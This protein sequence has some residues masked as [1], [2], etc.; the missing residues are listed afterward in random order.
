[1]GSIE[2][3]G[4]L[5]NKSEGETLPDE[6]LSGFLAFNW[7]RVAC[8][9]LSITQY[10]HGQV[11]CERVGCNYGDLVTVKERLVQPD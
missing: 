8:I 10:K 3:R 7:P 1:M 11:K 6:K 9:R 4:A 5:G 2:L